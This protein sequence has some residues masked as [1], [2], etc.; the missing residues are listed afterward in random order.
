MAEELKANASEVEMMKRN[1]VVTF[2]YDNLEKK[3][4]SI[5][6]G[7]ISNALKIMDGKFGGAFYASFL[8][9]SCKGY[10]WIKLV[11]EYP[12]GTLVAIFLCKNICRISNLDGECVETAKQIT[13]YPKG[14]YL[15]ILNGQ[16]IPTIIPKLEDSMRYGGFDKFACY[17]R[18]DFPI[19]MEV[20]WYRIVKLWE[21]IPIE[22]WDGRY[23]VEDV[24]R[25]LIEV[26]E[27]KA[28]KNEEFASARCV[29]LTKCEIEEV[30]GTMGYEF[31]NIRTL[32]DFRNLWL[33]DK[34]AMGYQKT[35][36]IDG[37][38]ERFY[39]LKKSFTDGYIKPNEEYAI[40]YTNKLEEVKQV[41]PIEK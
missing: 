25:S 3:N 17:E 7:L 16:K 35:K 26:G 40:P 30:I 41:T 20:I 24:Y 32:F 2:P 37:K 27:A 39:A 38:N 4:I 36:K 14:E 13:V 18:P 6:Q 28:L 21:K 23:N 8:F 9:D 10:G 11:L 12:D 19:P 33:K 1:A 15:P 34:N 29:Y 31:N 5:N 22:R